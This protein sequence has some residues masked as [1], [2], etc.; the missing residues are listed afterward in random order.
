MRI[1]KEN[2]EQIRRQISELVREYYDEEFMSK[3]FI[4]GRSSVPVAGRVFD[5]NELQYLVDSALDFWLT[6]GRFADEFEKEFAAFTGIR[7]Q[8]PVNSGSSANL[9]A[10]SA[11]MSKS[12]GRR[13]LQ[14]GDEVITVA[15]GFPTTVG[16]IIQ[17]GLVPVFVDIDLP[18]YNADPN[19]VEKAISEKTRAIILAHTLGNPFNLDRMKEIADKYALWLIEDCCDALGSQ[20]REG[21]VGQFGDIATFSFYP[22]HHITMGEGGCVATDNDTL[23]TILRSLRDWGRDCWCDPGS[24]NTCGERFDGRYGELPAGYDHK[25]VYSHFGYNLKITDMQAAVGLAQMKKLPKFIEA[26]KKNWAALREGLSGFAQ[27]FVLPESEPNS[28]PSWFGFLMTVREGAGFT[29]EHVV[30]HLESKRIQTRMLFAGNVVKQPCFDEMRKAGAGFRVA[31]DLKITDQ[32]MRDTF[33][34][35][36]Y[37]GLDNKM[38]EYMI[39]QIKAFTDNACA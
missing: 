35:G 27:Y 8:I 39:E 31:G 13:R 6:S 10:V 7:H 19:L 4:G 25:Y 18:S 34:I 36:V 24:D 14:P 2:V 33:W 28:S 11:L 30:R 20:Y 9:L 38:I 29:R 37:P 22:A 21:K 32:V 26:R 15:A 3:E 17:N 23:R 5:E 1:M 16:P 12:L